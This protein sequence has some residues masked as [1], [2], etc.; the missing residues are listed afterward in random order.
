[1]ISF[2]QETAV[3][4]LESAIFGFDQGVALDQ[5]SCPD[6]KRPFLGNTFRDTGLKYAGSV[7]DQRS[8]RDR[9]GV[10]KP[11]LIKRQRPGVGA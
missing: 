1:M 10:V 5:A 6:Q 11:E 4:Q 8:D 9:Q 2:S 3:D 7:L